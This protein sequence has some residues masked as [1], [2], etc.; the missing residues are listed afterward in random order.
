MPVLMRTRMALQLV[1]SCFAWLRIDLHGHAVQGCTEAWLLM[2]T[3]DEGLAGVLVAVRG[4]LR[5]SF[6]VACEKGRS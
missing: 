2:L 3:N 4:A 1:V 6:K 5:A